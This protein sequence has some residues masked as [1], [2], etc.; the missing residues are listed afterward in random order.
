MHGIPP[1]DF[2]RVI[3][4]ASKPFDFREPSDRAEW[5]DAIIALIA[6]LRSGNAN[7]GY[8]NN[9]AERNMLHKDIWE[10]TEEAERLEGPLR[11]QITP[12]MD[13]VDEEESEESRPYASPRDDK[14]RVLAQ[15][16]SPTLSMTE[17][18]SW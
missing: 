11:M 8:L 13:D 12:R 14:A 16:Q 5:F 1:P 7:V 17:I 6:Y 9:C 4:C 10:G 3:L 2:P 15:E 18:C